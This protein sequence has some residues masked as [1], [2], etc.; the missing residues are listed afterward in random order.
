MPGAVED[1]QGVDDERQR[2]SGQEIAAAAEDRRSV[3][4]VRSTDVHSVHRNWA[5][6]RN[7]LSAEDRALGFSGSTGRSTGAALSAGTQLSGS[8]G[9][10]SGRP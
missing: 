5:V 7:T 8:L 3:D 10:P 6:D 9:R 4:R 1:C 2:D